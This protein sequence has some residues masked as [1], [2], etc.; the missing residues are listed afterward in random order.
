[1]QLAAELD[2]I[3]GTVTWIS[4]NPGIATVSASGLVTGVAKGDTT[5]KAT[6]GEESDTC[7]VKVTKV[8]TVKL[9]DKENTTNSPTEIRIEE[10]GNVFNDTNNWMGS[11][12]YFILFINV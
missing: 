11:C 12:I 10:E 3:E 4:D 8:Y 2:G 5:I 7:S 9:Y 6:C 1:M